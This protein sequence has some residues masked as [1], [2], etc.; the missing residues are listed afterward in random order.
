[1]AYPI[2]LFWSG[3]NPFHWNSP[4]R[5]VIQRV[6]KILEID[7]KFLHRNEMVSNNAITTES[8]NRSAIVCHTYF[9]EPLYFRHR[10]TSKVTLEPLSEVLKK[11]SRWVPTWLGLRISGQMI[12]SW[13]FADLPKPPMFLIHTGMDLNLQVFRQNKTSLLHYESHSSIFMQHLSMI[14]WNFVCMTVRH[15]CNTWKSSKRI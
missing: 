10:S 12:S 8:F 1:M 15:T 6:D 5:L 7:G 2:G 13:M 14:Q 9:T 3:L 4:S 11:T